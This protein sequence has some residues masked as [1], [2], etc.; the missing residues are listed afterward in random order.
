MRGQAKT[1]KTLIIT[2]RIWLKY[3]QE[4]AELEANRQIGDIQIYLHDENHR[5]SSARSY[6]SSGPAGYFRADIYDGY[7][8]SILSLTDLLPGQEHHFSKGQYPIDSSRLCKEVLAQK[9]GVIVYRSY[10]DGHYT[11]YPPKESGPYKGKK[12]QIKPKG[13]SSIPL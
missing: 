8:W 6:M 4:E 9:E 3:E 12:G 5:Y 2:G 10:R 7:K 13:K 1:T 11:P